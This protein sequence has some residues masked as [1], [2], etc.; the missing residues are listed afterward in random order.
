YK[1]PIICHKS[2]STIEKGIDK[3]KAKLSQSLTYIELF[4]LG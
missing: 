1:E 4:G 3:N 2:A